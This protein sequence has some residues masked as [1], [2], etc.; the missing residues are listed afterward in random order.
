MTDED[1]LPF[2]FPTFWLILNGLPLTPL[3][4]SGFK[5][6]EEG[7]A[8]EDEDEDANLPFISPCPL[9]IG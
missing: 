6:E 9:T 3:G 8:E 1:L 4:F 5:G 2:P 7:E